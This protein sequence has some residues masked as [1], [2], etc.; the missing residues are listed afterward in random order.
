MPVD[1]IAASPPRINHGTNAGILATVVTAIA[2]P[3]NDANVPN[4]LSGGNAAH[5]TPNVKARCSARR[6][7]I[8]VLEVAFCG[9]CPVVC[10]FM[11]V[12]L[13][14]RFLKYES[15]WT[16]YLICYIEAGLFAVDTAGCG[17]A[18]NLLA[19]VRVSLVLQARDMLLCTPGMLLRC[20][21][22]PNLFLRSE[23]C[24]GWGG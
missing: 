15:R 12:L 16:Q 21:C 5:H 13:H 4:T 8:L 7:G 6:R 24:Q 17:A 9:N 2:K 23:Y 3:T 22:I 11:F 19:T 14:V 20:G 1:A 18:S 10:L